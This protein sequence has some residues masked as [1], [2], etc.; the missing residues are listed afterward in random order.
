MVVLGGVLA[1]GCSH[2]S[3]RVNQG[4]QPTM[5]SELAADFAYT[6][7][8]EL[9]TRISVLETKPEY[10]IKRVS[11]QVW[12]QQFSSNRW[13]ELDYYDLVDN[14][15]PTPVILVLP[16]LGGGYALERHFANYFATRG[17]ASIIVRRDKRS[18]GAGVNDL[19]WLF[20]DMVIDHKRVIDWVETQ[21][22]LDAKRLGIF[23]ISMGGIKGALLLPLENR[24]RAAALGLTGGDLPYIMAHS[25]EPGV[26]KRRE[27][28]LKDRN[29]TLEECEAKLREILKFDPIKYADY[30]DP[31][32]VLLVLAR[33][34]T[35]VPIEKGLE[36][37][38]KMGNPE[39]IMLPAGHYSAVLS[40]PYIK[41]QSFDFFEKHFAEPATTT[42]KKKKKNGGKTGSEMT[43]AQTETR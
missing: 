12:D 1:S 27:Q 4:R 3:F 30:V 39:T 9:T 32:K 22:D 13:I 2:S 28:E 41:S 15:K 40:I 34:D 11:L 38:K 26:A 8:A 16:M 29:M 5:P 19:N 33:Y 36:L 24:I 37:K 35:V 31:S 14:S 23:G 6:H 43:R 10:Q 18:K 25:T 42:T 7:P 20:R 17:Y 21:S